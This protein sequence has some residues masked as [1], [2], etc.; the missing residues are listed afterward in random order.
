MER[1]TAG[2]PW[3]IWAVGVVSA[4]WNAG[5]AYDYT[6]TYLQSATYLAPFGPE[7][8]A[9]FLGFPAWATA[10]WA[11]GVWG[12]LA[13]SLLLLA[14]SRFAVHAFVVALIGLMG[15]TAYQYTADMPA[16]FDTPG[17]HAFSAAIWIVT[18][19]LTAYA[20]WMRRRGV[21]I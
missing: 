17:T 19:A 4:I 11:L 5:G 9:Y 18:L 2:R 1:V 15:T 12:A 14:R 16:S 7:E 10:S 20:V 6:M 3:H 8:R 13:G 21:L